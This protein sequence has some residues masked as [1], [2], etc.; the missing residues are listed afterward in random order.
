MGICKLNLKM[1]KRVLLLVFVINLFLLLIT[2][3]FAQYSYLGTTFE[4][5]YGLSYMQSARTYGKG[6]YAIGIQSLAMQ[7]EYYV[8]ENNRITIPT[9][10]TTIIGI[11]ITVGITD[12]V[13]LSAGLYFFHDARS[14]INNSDV[15]EYYDSP[16]S[17]IGATRL[18]LKIRLP[19]SEERKFQV[20]GKLGAMVNSSQK[21][22]DG[23]NYRW[24]RNKG[25]DVEASLLETINLNSFM[26]LNIEQGYILS[27]SDIY[28][29]NIILAAGID[30]HPFSKWSFGLELQNH[31][32]MGISPQSVIKSVFDPFEYWD[33]Y[34]HLGDPAYIKD[35]NSDFAED[36]FVAVPSFSYNVNDLITLNAGAI[37]NIADQKG[38]NESVQFVVGITFKG[39][40]GLFVDTDGDGIKDYRDKESN[41][42]KGY[43]V[44]ISGIALDTDS[45]GIPDGIDKQLMTPKGAKVDQR[46][47]ALDSDG[48]GVYDGIDREPNTP[49]GCKVDTDGVA[50]DTDGDGVPNGLDKEPNTPQGVV[51]DENG[52][53]LPKPEP[54]VQPKPL[55]QELIAEELLYSVHVSSFR[56][57]RGANQEVENYRKRGY[58]SFTIFTTIPSMG[59]WYRVFV[60]RFKTEIEAMVEA[61]KLINLG[62][63]NYAKVMKIE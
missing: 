2:P 38:P 54:V 9:N 16:E 14:F 13:D 51:V 5:G 62:Y 46:G 35:S 43:P 24:T 48:D 57:I 39:S 21:Q 59:D 7:R 28:D 37:I 32:S 8:L 19:F 15:Y 41:T 44:N 20:A 61:Q 36:F 6:H 56:S 1:K 47:V 33:G 17:G 40:M 53:A 23:M 3:S 49:E 30:V 26:S 52:I 58:N 45:D 18:G 10:N 34:T 55:K 50:L 12:I 27:G 31:T 60:G 29:D 25:T 63:T 42:P 11:P 4:G 22:I